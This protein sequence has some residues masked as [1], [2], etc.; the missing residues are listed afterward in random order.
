[1]YVNHSLGLYS[2]KPPLHLYSIFGIF[3]SRLTMKIHVQYIMRY[4]FS[5][6]KTTG[7]NLDGQERQPYYVV[8]YDIIEFNE[9]LMICLVMV[10]YA[11]GGGGGGGGHL[12]PCTSPPPPPTLD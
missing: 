10:S 9:N 7:F 11:W 1:M 8:L 12:P 6:L 5:Y 2:H 4:Y 3:T